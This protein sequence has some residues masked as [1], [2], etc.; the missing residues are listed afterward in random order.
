MNLGTTLYTLI[1]GNL[2]G[3]DEY[4]NKYYCNSKN[5]ESELAKR[6]VIYFKE[7]EASKVPAHWHAWLH[8]TINKPPIDYKHKYK[9][10]KDHTQNMTGTKQAYF[11][12]SYPLSK[13]YNSDQEKNEYESW[14]P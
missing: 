5:F 6:W 1:Y 13:K 11:P 9:W 12:P 8:K 14:T 10:Q 2:V 3:K 4:G 7:I